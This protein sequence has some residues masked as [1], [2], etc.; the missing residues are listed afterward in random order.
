[1]ENFGK[2]GKDKVTGFEGIITAKAYFM[3]GCAQYGL[4]PPVDNEG[5]R[6]DLEYFDE[7]RIEILEPVI[8]PESV[9][10]EKNGCEKREYQKQ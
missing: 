2:K 4:C 1:M 9:K 5:K 10:V 6:R 7:G 8:N 3:Y